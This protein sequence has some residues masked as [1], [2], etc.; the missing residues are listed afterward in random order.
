MSGVWFVVSIPTASFERKLKHP[1]EYK[2]KKDHH[3]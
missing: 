1:E 2:D 3:N